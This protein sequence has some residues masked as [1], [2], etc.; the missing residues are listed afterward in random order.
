MY[1]DRRYVWQFLGFAALMLVVVIGYWVWV[2]PRIFLAGS[3][4]IDF[5]LGSALAL[6]LELARWT[7][8]ISLPIMV[9]AV[10][11]M[12]DFAGS[13]CLREGLLLLDVVWLIGAAAMLGSIGYSYA[14]T[15][16]ISA[17]A[18]FLLS[19]NVEREWLE[20]G[21]GFAALL[22]FAA[23]S[24]WMGVAHGLGAGVAAMIGFAL[25]VPATL[26][27]RRANAALNS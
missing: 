27:T 15:L 18:G 1:W 11:K 13:A 16:L 22:M 20:L 23:V 9:W 21:D 14:N 12:N 19:V 24:P 25:G 8:L 5:R 2:A 6:R 4:V 17:V 3:E 7:G 26:A 10:C